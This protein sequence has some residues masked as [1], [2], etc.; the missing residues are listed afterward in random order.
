[1]YKIFIR[2]FLC[3]IFSM[4]SVAFAQS[5]DCQL[6][7]YHLKNGQT[8]LIK[9]NHS[10]PIATVDT[11]VKTGSLNENDKN[12][13]VSHFLEHLMFKGSKN[14]PTGEFSK[15]IES[16]G[17]QF[18]AA[19]SKDFTHFYVTIPSK[20]LETAIKLHADM[21][22]NAEVPEKE[23]KEERKVVIEEIR[24]SEDNPS[25]ILFDNLMTLVFKTHP[26]RRTILGPK[27]NI[28]NISRNAILDY[29]HKFYAPSNMTTIVIGDIEPKK[30]L[31]LLEE[32]FKTANS[33]N[34]PLPAYLHEKPLSEARIK[35]KKGNYNF[36]YL[37]MGFKGVTIKDKKDNFALDLASS[38]L[39][40]GE[41]SRLYQEL[42]EKQNIVSSIGAGNY[43]MRDD[44][45]FLV[46]ADFEPAKYEK[47]KTEI[48]KQ[49]KKLAETKVTQEELNRA[50]TQ[51]ERAFVYGNESIDEIAGTVGYAMTLDGS[52]DLYTNYLKYIK[53]ITAED[54]QKAVKKYVKPS[55]MA[56]SVILPEKIK[57]ASDDTKNQ[58]IK[59]NSVSQN[60]ECYKDTTKSVL[61]NGMTLITN[62][63]TSNDIISLSI[64]IKGGKLA[65]FPAGISG[66]LTDTLMKGTKTKNA[67]EIAKSIE[68]MGIIIA[69]SLNSDYFQI[70]LKSTKNDFDKAFE[71]LTDIMNNPV[72]PTEYVEKGKKDILQDIV[73]SRDRPLSRASEKFSIAMYPNHPYGHTG[74]VLEKSVPNLNRSQLTEL[75][76]KLFIPQNMVVSVSGNVNPDEIA[77]KFSQS[78][79]AVQGEKF[80]YKIPQK[81]EKLTNNK[82]VFQND[83]TSAAWIL[84]GWP[85]EGLTS[86]KDSKDYEVLKVIDSILSGGMSSRLH[87]TFREKQGLAYAV[88]SDYSSKMDKSFLA[89]YIG[90]EPKNIELVKSKFL[91][92]M[93]KLKTEKV[94]EDELNDAKQKIIGG[95]LMGQETNQQKASLLGWFEIVDKGYKYTYNF[96]EKINSVTAE[97]VMEIAN[98]YFNSPYVL[99]IVAPKN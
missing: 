16:K 19:T 49:L 54:I 41:S 39:G 84:M 62:K 70:Q 18:N 3:F 82:T 94:C 51:A 12:N 10:N 60:K 74:E 15:I 80:C 4:S 29:Y 34:I 38:I 44:S 75:H 5:S 99:S 20:D 81:Q 17:G 58:E 73:K 56:L 9:E 14:Y 78:F 42:K 90:T 72:F 48:E 46:S 65:D 79:P 98:K 27:E 77:Q 68:D 93:T 67:L 86:I 35:I 76:K 13:G 7:I 95:Y 64:Y 24:R 30:V 37:D 92:E 22:I 55:N 53:N 61:N 66:L 69:P 63:N 31:C 6:Q 28:E 21:M 71:I 43:S 26:Y 83:K 59:V 2:I 45:I 36:G 11:W 97:D 8:V 1:M 87:I 47:V 96:P 32:N 33:K 88:G 40:G 23:L 89:L 52:P 25:G 85:V 50:K 91:E 57:K